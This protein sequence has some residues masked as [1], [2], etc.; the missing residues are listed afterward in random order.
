VNVGSSRL[1]STPSKEN[2]LPKRKWT[3]KDFQLAVETSVSVRQALSKLG[4][5]PAGG[6]YAVFHTTVERLA[7]D[8]SHFTQQAWSKGLKLKPKRQLE[9]YLSNKFPIQSHKL[10]LRLLREGIKEAVCESCGLKEWLGEP[11][12][13]ELDHIDGNK[14]NNKLENLRILCP[15]CHAFTPT[16][17]GKNKSS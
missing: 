9:D 15:N 6:N 7:L 8:L 16:Y 5:R 1:V 4:L 12:P 13:L 2:V 14:K 10:R 11:I 3:D 17:R